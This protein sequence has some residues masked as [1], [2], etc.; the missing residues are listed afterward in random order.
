VRPGFFL[1][2]EH[3]WL[4]HRKKHNIPK[5]AIVLMLMKCVSLTLVNTRNAGLK[6]A[7]QIHCKHLSAEEISWVQVKR[8]L[9]FFYRLKE[10]RTKENQYDKKKMEMRKNG[11]IRILLD[12]LRATSLVPKDDHL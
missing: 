2:S 8:T 7:K 6:K 4:A 10:S 1:S 12:L 9:L 11:L 5:I 3:L